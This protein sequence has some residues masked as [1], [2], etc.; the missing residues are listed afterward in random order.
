[1][2]RD[3][4]RVSSPSASGVRFWHWER[5]Q[6]TALGA[7]T[8]LLLHPTGVAMLQHQNTPRSPTP[9]VPQPGFTSSLI[10]SISAR[11][12]S[13]SFFRLSICVSLQREAGWPHTTVSPSV[14][15][16]I[17]VP[18]VP[19]AIGRPEGLLKYIRGDLEKTEGGKLSQAAGA[20][21]PCPRVP[22]PPPCPHLRLRGGS[23]ADLNEV[24][25]L[26]VLRG[27]FG[28]DDHRL[29]VLGQRRCPQEIWGAL[30]GHKVMVALP[31][32]LGTTTHRP[33]RG[34]R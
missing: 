12:I 1:M 3:R 21:P 7:T 9:A 33:P 24:L 13:T 29:H 18:V 31:G 14:P 30:Q 2:L 27:F 25:R 11:S 10:F 19:N 5:P 6:N 34:G 8:P 17:F 23:R 26:L 28:D 22:I 4:S 16:Q 20:C 15:P 32:V